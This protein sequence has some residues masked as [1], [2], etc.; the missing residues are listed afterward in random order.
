M[1]TL[2]KVSKSETWEEPG[3]RGQTRS[4]FHGLW[5]RVD[6]WDR[7]DAERLTGSGKVQDETPDLLRMTSSYLIVETIVVAATFLD[8]HA[9]LAV[10]EK[11]G[12]TLAALRTVIRAL[13]GGTECRAAQGAGVCAELIVA[14]GGALHRCK[15]W[16][17]FRA[18][19]KEGCRAQ[20][21]PHLC[22]SL[23]LSVPWSLPS[24]PLTHDRKIHSS[25]V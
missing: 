7:K 19:G 10:I 22:L 9:G 8:G 6:G 14:V 18:P 17:W 4:Q 12:V 25:R 20:G 3:K 16:V 23:P 5:K 24:L 1:G 13:R 11:A 21:L 15:E 2:T